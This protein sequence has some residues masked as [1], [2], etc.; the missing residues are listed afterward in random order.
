[1]RRS[2]ASADRR[3]AIAF[4]VLLV[5]VAIA[6][7]QLTRLGGGGSDDRRAESAAVLD[8]PP[9][10]EPPTTTTSGPMSYQ[11]Q[12]GDTLTVIARRF[13]VSID[14]IVSTN[15]LPNQDSLSIGQVLKIP[16]APP[17]TLVV[18]PATTSGGRSVQ[19]ELGGAKRSEAVTFK[20]DSPTGS[21][22][23]PSHI[24]Q[25]DGTVTTRYT[26]PLDATPG[27]YAVSAS[28][29]QG[30]TAQASFQVEAPNPIR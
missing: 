6:A 28:G 29:N 3:A 24:A 18:T 4:V 16:P 7:F 10:T 23:G 14:T 30:T 5:V 13:G 1:M 19:I 20:I 2:S 8:T 15:Q 27:T 12:R 26:P 9:P 25:E 22:T 11:V 21:F 17:V